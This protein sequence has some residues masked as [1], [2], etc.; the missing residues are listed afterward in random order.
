MRRKL[1]VRVLKAA[2]ESH[3]L[4]QC[5]QR[6]H[7]VLLRHV[8]AHLLTATRT[9]IPGRERQAQTH[10]HQSLHQM[11]LVCVRDNWFIFLY[12]VR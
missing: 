2:V 4:K 5:C 8:L 12:L 9:Q 3:L 11:L 7:D 1:S 6:S 10:A